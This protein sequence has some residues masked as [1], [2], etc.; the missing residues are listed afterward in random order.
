LSTPLPS[1]QR[2]RWQPL[3]SGLINIYR[4]DAEEFYFEDGHLLL[5]GNN[6]TGK[7]R[8]LALQLPFLLDGEISPRRLEPDGDPSKRIEWNLL[9][10]KY[11]DRCGYTWIE[12]GRLDEA[13]HEHYLT[14]AIGLLAVKGQGL[15]D[16]WYVVTP[17]RVGKDFFLQ[18][19]DRQVFGKKQLKDEFS[20]QGLV[21]SLFPENA[22]AYRRA[23]DEALFHLG[24]H[25][26][27]AL[28]ELLIQLRHPQLSRN[29]DERKLSAVLSEA[30]PPL[31]NLILT[32]IAESFRNLE[33]EQ[34]KLEALLLVLKGLESFAIPYRRYIQWELRERCQNLLSAHHQVEKNQR[35]VK[36]GEQELAVA[37]QHSLELVEQERSGELE[38]QA[39]QAQLIA[40]ESSPEMKDARRLDDLKRQLEQ[41]ER[42]HQHS[43]QNVLRA[44]NQHQKN[45]QRHSEEEQKRET[46]FNSLQQVIASV[47][48]HSQGLPLGQPSHELVNWEVDSPTQ[49]QQSQL[50]QRVLVWKELLTKFRLQ[51]AHLQKLQ[52]ELKSAE[53]HLLMTRRQQDAQRGVV[54]QALD[55]LEKSQHQLTQACQ[56][57]WENILLWNDGLKGLPQ[58]HSAE[59]QSVFE[60]WCMEPQGENPLQPYVQQSFDT[61]F[62]NALNTQKELEGSIQQLQQDFQNHQEEKTKLLAGIDAG[63]LPNPWKNLHTRQ[64]RDGAPLWQVLDFKESLS[65][66]EKAGLEA[67]L[68]ASGLL[69][70]WLLPNG[71]LLRSGETDD[72]FVGLEAQTQLPAVH[73]GTVLKAAIDPQ[74][75]AAQQLREEDI[76]RVLEQIGWGEQDAPCWICIESEGVLGRGTFRLGPQRGHWAK[77]RAQHLGLRARSETRRRRCAELESFMD[78]IEQQLAVAKRSHAEVQQLQ[79]TLQHERDTF[80]KS[81]LIQ[82]GHATLAQVQRQLEASRQKMQQLDQAVDEAQ[83]KLKPLQAE[84]EASAKDFKLEIWLGKLEPLRNKL[85]ELQSQLKDWERESQQWMTC[86]HTCAQLRLDEIEACEHL[87][88]EQ[89]LERELVS[90][91]N[92]HRQ[93]WQT[94]HQTAGQNIQDLQNQISAVRQQLQEGQKAQKKLQHQK[95]EL[96]RLVVRHDERLVHLKSKLEELNA[97]R[98]DHVEHLQCL[99]ATGL[100]Q[101]V[102]SSQE[103]PSSNAGLMLMDQPSSDPDSSDS[104]NN[105]SLDQQV[106]RSSSKLSVSSAIGMAR[107][108]LAVLSPEPE[109]IVSGEALYNQAETGIRPLEN[110]LGA[111]GG[112]RVVRHRVN[113]LLVVEVEYQARRHNLSSLAR[114][115]N[116]EIHHRQVILDG[117]ERDILEKHL[118]GEVAAHLHEMIHHGEQWVLE[119]NR[120]LAKR[121]MDTGMQLRFAWRV[122]SDQDEAL[123]QAR[124]Q[125]LSN[126]GTWSES[127]RREMGQ[128]LHNRIRWVKSQKNGEGSWVEHLQEAFDYRSWH[129]FQVELKKSHDSTWKRMTRHVFGTGSGGEKAVALTLPQFAAA[130]AHYRSAQPNAPRLIMMDEVFVGVDSDMRGKCMGLL[131]VFDLDFVM[132]SEREW[133]TY[134]TVSG[135]AIYQLATRPGLEAV[136][137]TRWVWNGK[138]RQ[139]LESIQPQVS[140]ENGKEEGGM[141]M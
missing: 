117:H 41:L 15:N 122:L 128:F 36:Q 131:Q 83:G 47:T 82:Q 58:L 84:L 28:V 16:R 31:P 54:E 21:D 108:W 118:I 7:S 129:Q 92:S 130:A 43:L 19:Q 66:N 13:G 6:G 116:G 107:Q 62:R 20:K 11:D 9:M 59:L 70:A 37:R 115:L 127:Q 32:D 44:Q 33:N 12:F 76:H 57:V 85:D 124:Q 74:S 119:V 5:R 133:G 114:I 99:L 29:L 91:L 90:R 64:G 67:A 45:L 132:T 61:S 86:L 87:D 123:P 27:E 78:V 77:D 55:D 105:N 38:Q 137:V 30:L 26:Y 141:L 81:I 48:Q 24:E 121:P 50:Q 111:Q 51:L 23:V 113:E 125:L 69:D 39:A 79:K 1:P 140:E 17:H 89:D 53:Q 95:S 136:G 126:S 112:Y 42:D 40:L 103:G 80:P 72:V 25:R 73:L 18:G 34:N 109:T 93:Q 94:L 75:S 71:R 110:I 98:A 52:Q 65:E 134:P 8:V 96:E 88:Q 101:L 4:Y 63:P 138:E 120:E 35:E 2:Q 97:K 139:R 22:R 106:E 49:A 56:A 102:L 60:V 100:Q 46:I 135:L 14:L 68:E 10:D 104:F 3:R